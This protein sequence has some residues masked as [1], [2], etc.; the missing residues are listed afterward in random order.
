MS[1]PF[2]SVAAQNH[3][4]RIYGCATDQ[5][6]RPWLLTAEVRVRPQM[7]SV[8]FVVEEVALEQDFSELLQFSSTNHHSPTDPY[9][10][11]Q[12]AH[13]HISVFKRGASP[14][15]RYVAGHDVRKYYIYSPILELN[16]IKCHLISRAE[17]S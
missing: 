16:L 7:T 6:V 12:A 14:L 2:K 10:S 1:V 9:S 17:L 11:D 4:F 5:A 15:I 3:I 8:R 13:Y